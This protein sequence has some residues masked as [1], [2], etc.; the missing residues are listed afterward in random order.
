MLLD[1]VEEEFPEGII[2]V[3]DEPFSQECVIEALRGSFPHERLIGIPSV[4]DLYRPD[5]MTVTA[6][7]MKARA[8]SLAADVIN[9]DLKAVARYF[10]KTPVI[11][12]SVYDDDVNVLEAFAAG[13]RGVVP[14]TVSL[15]IGIAAIRLVMAGGTYYPRPVLN[16]LPPHNGVMVDDHAPIAPGSLAAMDNG[17]PAE[18]EQGT[19]TPLELRVN[20]LQVTFTAREA[21]VLA[22][23]QKG[24]S[25][26]WIA[27]QLNLSQN[28]IKVHI[29]HIMRKLNATNRT[30][31]VILS[32]RVAS[33]Y[34]GSHS[35]ALA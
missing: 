6:L 24:R 10:P 28:T 12:I 9:S 4:D 17:M 14:V 2:V 34:A 22:A 3:D 5:G 11:L 8:R 35:S 15:K 21:E 19:D 23:L 1:R 33:H 26:K 16:N 31:A 18:W 25:N 32:Q 13:V 7:L 30:E 27:N 20:G 29:R